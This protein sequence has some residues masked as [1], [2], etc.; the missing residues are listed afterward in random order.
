MAIFWSDDFLWIYNKWPRI[1]SIPV[2]AWNHGHAKDDD[3][4][5]GVGLNA[6]LIGDNDNEGFKAANQ[7]ANTFTSG[8]PT[9]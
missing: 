5:G 1:S 3:T 4:E 6:S 2:N 8:S 7:F 9:I